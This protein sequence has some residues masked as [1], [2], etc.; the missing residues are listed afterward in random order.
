MKTKIESYEIRAQFDGTVRSVKMKVGDIVGGTSSSTTNDEGVIYIENA[1]RVNI[2]VSLDQMDIV[3][4]KPGQAANI[5]FSAFPDKTFTGAIAEIS[6][7][8][9]SDSS[10]VSYSVIV[11]MSR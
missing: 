11:S 3:K 10:S 1:D 5:R 7:T 9:S 8:P 2:I 4:V 6:N